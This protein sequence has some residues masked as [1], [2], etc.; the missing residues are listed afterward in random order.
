[1][2]YPLTSLTSPTSHPY[3][4]TDDIQ[5]AAQ[6][7][8]GKVLRTPVWRW[9]TG[10]VDAVLD[11]AT[12]VWLKL[13]LF[14]KTGTFK[15]RGA[16]NSIAGIGPDARA[17]GVVAVSAG[18]HAIAVAYAAAQYG[19]PATV[20]MPR[21]ASPVRIAAC[22]A[23]GADVVLMPDIHQAFAHGAR[24]EA[25][26][27]RT[28]VH[29]FDGPLIAQ[30]TATLGLELLEQVPDLDAVVVPVGGGGLCGGIAAAVKQLRP[31]CKVFGVEPFGADAM[32][33]SFRAGRPE[34]LESVASIADSL[35]APFALDYSYQVCRRFVDDIV[36]VGD[37]DICRAMHWLYRD[38]KL[39]AEPAAAT[40]TAA[41]FGPLRNMLR[42]QRVALLVCG[43]NI[44]AGRFAE[45]VGRGAA[46]DDAQC[47]REREFA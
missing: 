5:A 12:E 45:L 24:I 33:R 3:P 39:V 47:G 46:L 41:L 7:L 29:P 4:S 9:Q 19:A 23:H 21:H 32:F 36:R 26:Q 16:L 6:R 38:M 34:R 13:E 37:D 44:D 27:G 20:V 42:G 43:S 1:M 17:R 25:E 18:N 11:E 15:V 31:S 8:S 14:Q 35:G 22:R 30:G 2:T 28:M 10:A 40:A